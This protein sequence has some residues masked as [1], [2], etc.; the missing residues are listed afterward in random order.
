MHGLITDQK[1][2][3]D[4]LEP[5]LAGRVERAA[6]DTETTLVGDGGFTPYGTDTRI[7]GFSV[8][9]DHQGQEVDLY[10]AVRHQ[11]YDW[12][13]SAEAM[14][15][16]AAHN[17]R[18]WV[19]RLGLEEGVEPAAADGMT[20][21]WQDGWDPNLEL[22]AVQALWQR[23]MD[24]EGVTWYAHNWPFDARM[25][26]VE[27][28]T[29]PWD[30]MECTQ[31][32]SVFTD[33]R[34][35]DLWDDTL[36]DG[37]GGFVHGGH[38]LKHLGETWLNTPAEAQALL[39]E[40]KAAMG[41]GSA[42][43]QD[44]SMLPLRTVLAPYACMDTRL[45]MRL[46]DCCEAREAYCDPEVKALLDAHRAEREHCV[47]MERRGLPV[48][49][50]LCKV[51]AKEKEAE[52][53][54][55]V[56]R[57]NGLAGIV[58]NLGHGET[59]AGQLYDELG[60]PTHQVGGTAI[61]NTMEAT[62]KHV[63]TRIVTDDGPKAEDHAHLVDTILQYRKA[64]KE[65]TTF[66]RPLVYFGDTGRVHTVLSPLG[67][68]TTRYASEKPN[69]MQ[70]SKPRK[71]ATPE[72]TRA[73]QVA[74]VRHVF[75]PGEGFCLVLPD[76]NGQEMRVA[77]HYTMAIPELFGY[78]FTWT[79][80]MGKRGS[81]KGRTPH[82]PKGDIAAC[83]K[84]IHTGYR[85]NYS[86]RPQMM[87]LADGFMQQGTSFDPH[88]SMVKFCQLND[89]DVDRDDAKNVDF[90]IL[91]GAGIKKLMDMLNCTWEQ[92]R[93]VFDIF[94]QEAYPELERV[95][96]F[97]GERL[98]RTGPRSLYSHQQYVRSIY[99]G[100]IHLDDSYKGP[101]YVVQRSCREML[102]HAILFVQAYLEAEKAAHV[103]QLVLP[104]HDELIFH[105]PTDQLDQRIVQGIC[106]RMVEA[107]KPSLVPMVVEPKVAYESWAVKESLPEGWGCDGMQLFG[108]ATA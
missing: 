6:F 36:K 72:E 41:P 73:N 23:L 55:L 3:E 97:I 52:V 106:Q 59:L 93:K 17:G 75:K 24:V 50:E 99:G 19:K 4:A 10:A 62:L 77:A 65:L 57:A 26:D 8:S 89:V 51:R 60:F 90:A 34:P 63:R 71:G 9:F 108:G 86:R 103:Y 88:A 79:C 70:M 100:R 48:D 43:L 94:W 68:R 82:G 69:A 7:A 27:G 44:Y 67:A 76:Y 28:I 54:S 80:T 61:R 15:K 11:P 2:L 32:L 31:A 5:I 46:A 22:F 12:R 58:L 102:L 39:E 40:A 56:A 83:R 53:A 42:K 38:A 45:V 21:G 33:P 91:Y 105:V 20:F 74:S 25:L 18:D 96:L 81:C 35:L 37:R 16:D 14:A 78:R 13:R 98:R 85:E 49:Q 107:G 1:G 84:F 101:N 30:R 87:G 64:D 104:V 95:K 29:L 92:A 47:A 66:Y